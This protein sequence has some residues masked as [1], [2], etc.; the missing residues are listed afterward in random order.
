MITPNGKTAYVLN[1]LGGTVTP[2]R[3]AGNKAGTPYN[4]PPDAETM[5]ITP[6]G[7]TVYVS[8]IHTVVPISTATAT[9]RPGKPI[10]LFDAYAMAFTPDSR[11]LYAVVPAL[12]EIFPVST[13]TNK[14]GRPFP[15]GS[16]PGEITITPD[17]KTAYVLDINGVIPFSTA[18]NTVGALIRCDANGPMAVTANGKTLYVVD[19]DNAV[20]PISTATNTA[21]RPIPTGDNPVAIAITP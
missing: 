20:T 4:M 14:V 18:T 12:A 10:P 6:N 15:V 17:G 8:A 16:E 1:V 2:I 5:V 7:R 3:I 11:T 19:V 9:R 21:C 13:A